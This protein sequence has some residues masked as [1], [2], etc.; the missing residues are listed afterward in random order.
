MAAAVLANGSVILNISRDS[1]KLQMV[2]FLLIRHVC[3]TD[4]LGAM[5]VLPVPLLAVAKV[6]TKINYFYKLKLESE[7]HKLP[8]FINATCSAYQTC[9]FRA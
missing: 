8:F 5:L 6:R 9:K 1:L 7:T 2:H 3:I 4:C